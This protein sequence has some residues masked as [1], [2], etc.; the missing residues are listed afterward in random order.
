MTHASELATEGYTIVELYD[1][2]TV[3]EL[4]ARFDAL[5][6]DPDDPFVATC[7]DLP[8]ETAAAVQRDVVAAAR[9]GLDR[10]VPH[11]EPF[12]AGFITKGRGGGP[13]ELHQ[14]LTYTDERRYR[15]VLLWAPLVD[16]DEGSG[17]LRVIP[18]SHR[19][20]TGIRPG[21]VDPQPTAAHREAL[22]RRVVTV[23][24]RAGQAL[25][26]DAA[27]VHGSGPNVTDEARPAVAIATAP[28]GADLVHF[29][30]AGP[31]GEIVGH[32]VDGRYYEQQSVRE[33]PRGHEP[34]EAWARAVAS[35][36]F[37]RHLGPGAS[38]RPVVV[39]PA[40]P[41]PPQ[42][43]PLVTTRRARHLLPVP[44]RPALADPA[45]DLRLRRDGFVRFPL[46]D[47]ASARALREQYG[48]VHG[49]RGEGF[50]ADLDNEDSEYRRRVSELLAAALDE[51]VLARFVDHAPFLRVFLCKWPGEG[52]DLYLHRDWMY[53]DERAGLRTYVVWIALQDV[54]GEQGQIQVLRHSHRVDPMLR[55]TDLNAG[56]IQCE[57]TIRPR[58]LT[59]P[60]R[61]GEALVMDNSL[62][63]CS[64]PNHTDEPRVVAAVGVRPSEAPLVHF[65]RRDG[66]TAER[67]DVDEDFFLT[68]TPSQLMAAPPDRP[69]AE[70]ATI[71]GE[72]LT[73]DELASR[74]GSSSLARVDALRR[75]VA[76]RRTG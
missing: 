76:G 17:A 32:R 26:Y 15:S 67:F 49:W 48:R 36:D 20:T 14:D 31:G 28:A 4:R 55:G 57:A 53:V 2:A 24:L 73:G 25:L 40:P 59:V 58:L 42:R 1:G 65:R 52:S 54:T 45:L 12:L 38:E 50:E 19:W 5:D 41:T 34:I 61:A 70:V 74:L 43:R 8:R 16:V 9:S 37:E 69:V 30:V 51:V 60:V 64:L 13:V 6:I 7:N 11:H 72:E 29:H 21:G 47:P 75:V 18:G 35:D 3:G 10:L 62:V 39:V 63:H 33:V 23:P 44:S 56:W 68:S 22:E 71:G 46:I 27:L 66:L